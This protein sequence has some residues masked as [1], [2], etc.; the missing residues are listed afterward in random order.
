MKNISYL[1]IVTMT[2]LTTP[3]FA[4]LGESSASIQTDRTALHASRNE[5]T[6]GN[7]L[8]KVESYQIAA[9]TDIKE[10]VTND[11]M[12][13]AVSWSGP[14]KPDLQQLLGKHYLTLTS[15][16]AKKPHGGRSPVYIKRR[17]IVIE[18]GGHPRSFFGRAYLPA[19]MP[20]GMKDSD[21]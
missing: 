17:D 7:E 3:C 13:F 6:T 16:I 20:A 14:I 4:T 1:F 10:Y 5:L 12:V 21:I 11:G 8:Y 15:A 2:L 9:A 19:V 18:S